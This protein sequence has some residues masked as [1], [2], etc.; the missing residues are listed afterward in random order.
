MVAYVREDWFGAIGVQI[1]WS[2]RRGSRRIE[3]LGSAH[4]GSG[5]EGLKAA[6]RQRLMDGQ[7]VLDLGLGST[8]VT[9]GPLEIVGFAGRA[10]VGRVV[11]DLRG[12]RVRP[13]RWW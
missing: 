6:A 5:V 4:D 1:V 11:P 3:H 13:R 9:G 2:S 10:S 7:G 12:A 8:E